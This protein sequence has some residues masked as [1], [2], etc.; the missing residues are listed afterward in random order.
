MKKFNKQPAD[1]LDYTVDLT[2]WMVSGDTVT[3]TNASITPSGP[4]IEVTQG[5]SSQPKIWVSGGT[6]GKQYKVTTTIVTNGGR[7]KEIDFN[8]LVTEI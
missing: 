3:S 1:V 8:V 2:N 6:N 5:A 4:S 7:T